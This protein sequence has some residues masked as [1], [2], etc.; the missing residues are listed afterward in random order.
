[1]CANVHATKYYNNEGY[2]L[3]SMNMVSFVLMEEVD[4][5]IPE[6][7]RAVGPDYFGN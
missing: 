6:V 4:K 1:M 3:T 5:V 2:E 7:K